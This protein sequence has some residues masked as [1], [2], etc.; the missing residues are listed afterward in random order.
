MKY[1]KK[2]FKWF[3]QTFDISDFLTLI[4]LLLIFNGLYIYEPY[5]AYII[6]GLLLLIITIQGRK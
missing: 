2:I 4:S 5:L 1:I 6:T 3:Y